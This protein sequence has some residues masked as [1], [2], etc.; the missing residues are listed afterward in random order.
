MLAVPISQAE[1]V[2]ISGTLDNRFSDNM[3]RVAANEQSDLETRLGLSIRHVKDPGTCNSILDGQL[4]YGYWL[5]DTFD[6]KVYTDLGFTGD[7]E[8]TRGFKWLVSDRLSD[9]TE[10]SQRPDVPDNSTRK[11]V[12]TTGPQ[13]TLFLTS[14]DQLQFT[15]QYQNTEFEEPEESD[16]ERVIAST[17]W[18]HLFSSTLNGGIS[19]SSNRAELD[20]GVEIDRNTASL[21]FAKTW[22]ATKLDGSLGVS[23]IETSFGTGSQ[24]SDALV[25]DLSLVREINPSADFFLNF[26]RELSDQTSDFDFQF[27]EFEFNLTETTGVEVT[28]LR[29]GV[30]KRFSDGT[31]LNFVLSAS[32]SD[33]LA[34]DNTE[35][36]AGTD[37]FVTRPL[38]ARISLSSGLGFDYLTYEQDDSDD[39]VLEFNLGAS[40]K[41][42]RDLGVNMKVGHERRTSDVLSREYQENWI[43]IGLSY[44]F[45]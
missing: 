38:T 23:E 18:N 42:S 27:G 43:L 41:L 19:L 16:S 31:T 15:L 9:V 10:S 28:A 14:R 22:P 4:G 39:T 35:E 20:S 13:Y 12:F 8:L 2:S 29:A 17:A 21:T 37:V 5:E 45:L 33:Y 26:S 3:G 34:S 1:P 7:C 30:D 6:P 36:R 24:K 44:R 25:G 11:N 40:Y 32:Q